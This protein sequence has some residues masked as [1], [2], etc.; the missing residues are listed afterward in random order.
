[1][2]TID[3]LGYFSKS[4]LV[5]TLESCGCTLAGVENYLLLRAFFEDGRGDEGGRAGVEDNLVLLCRVRGA[6]RSSRPED[7]YINVMKYII[8]II[9]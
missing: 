3:L 8:V 1:M 4:E 5:S 2:A 9:Y 6:V 7:N